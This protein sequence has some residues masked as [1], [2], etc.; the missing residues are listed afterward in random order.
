ME[1]QHSIVDGL[2]DF[3]ETTAKNVLAVVCGAIPI[4]G[5]VAANIALDIIERTEKAQHN[6]KACKF[7][8]SYVKSSLSTI[9]KFQLQGTIKESQEAYEK[10]LKDIKLYVIEIDK[11][12]KFSEKINNWLKSAFNANN[13]EAANERIFQL[14]KDATDNFYKAVSLD[15][16]IQVK[17]IMNEIEEQKE[18]LLAIKFMIARKEE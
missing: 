9:A 8:Q 16:N 1:E 10:I 14:L 7:I 17:E 3:G 18:Q 12:A 5:N 2:N 4:I 11:P 15:T 13:I 6:K